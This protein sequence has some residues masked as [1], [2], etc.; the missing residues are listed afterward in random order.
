MFAQITK[1]Y[2]CNKFIR[3]FLC[4]V[5]SPDFEFKMLYQMYVMLIF[6]LIAKK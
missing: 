2:T 6:F 1:K 4:D 3:L 5:F